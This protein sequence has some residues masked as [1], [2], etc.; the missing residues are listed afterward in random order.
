MAR[1]RA[2]RKPATKSVGRREECTGGVHAD[3]LERRERR[4]LT[5]EEGHRRA[6]A[7]AQQDARAALGSDDRPAPLAWHRRHRR[8]RCGSR[9][10]SRRA[11]VR[12]RVSPR[13]RARRGSRRRANRAPPPGRSPDAP[14]RPSRDLAGP[15]RRSAA[16]R[17]PGAALPAPKPGRG[18]IQ[19][20]ISPA[21]RPSA[22]SGIAPFEALV[23]PGRRREAAPAGRRQIEVE[24]VGQ[25]QAVGEARGP[26]SRAVDDQRRER[27][28][29]RQRRSSPQ[30]VGEVV[31]LRPREPLR[32]D[33]GDVQAGEERL[34]LGGERCLAVRLGR[35]Q[36]LEHPREGGEGAQPVAGLPG[37]RRDRDRQQQ[38]R[39]QAGGRAPRS[40]DP[41]SAPRVRCRRAAAG[42]PRSRSRA[43]RPRR[44]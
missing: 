33:L 10:R 12:A 40:P 14:K 20:R 29:P 18:T 42:G 16:A 27:I 34:E 15:P 5:G 41:G 43:R 22:S 28:E 39:R 1:G 9:R 2:S 38:E 19:N 23:P 13:A 24:T 31:L 8:Q 4:E 17:S 3:A 44:R 32:Q 36:R 7:L 35:R 26:R 37:G 25:R 21:G 11:P 30:H 6:A